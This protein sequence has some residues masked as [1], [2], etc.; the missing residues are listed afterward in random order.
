M[1]IGLQQISGAYSENPTLFLFLKD[2]TQDLFWRQ[3]IYTATV[4][5]SV[6]GLLYVLF[7]LGRGVTKGIE[8][9]G[10]KTGF[11]DILTLENRTAKK[12][13]KIFSIRNLFVFWLMCGAFLAIFLGYGLSGMLPA[14]FILA[15]LVSSVL[16]KREIDILSSSGFTQRDKAWKSLDFRCVELGTYSVYFVVVILT[17]SLGIQLI[18]PSSADFSFGNVHDDWMMRFD[19]FVENNPEMS[20]HI[21][22]ENISMYVSEFSTWLKEDS[23]NFTSESTHFLS[24]ALPV[25]LIP[26]VIVYA[27]NSYYLRG[28]KWFSSLVFLSL[29]SI[30]FSFIY[31]F[32]FAEVEN[33]LLMVVTS[34][35]AISLSMKILKIFS[36]K[37]WTV[38][39]PGCGEQIPLYD[40]YCPYCGAKMD[41]G[42]V[43]RRSV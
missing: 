41:K 5:L 22:R 24:G 35:V 21:S 9:I 36:K 7:M 40:N 3:F 10:M 37:W 19:Q 39:C 20:Q 23:L 12:F 15:I 18:V 38:I 26:I 1:Y 14:I 2:L 31:S 6:A 16:A 34:I 8:K 30:T 29:A 28:G 25:I 4:F 27:L 11:K 13:E 33:P 17:L 32:L 43:K 42:K